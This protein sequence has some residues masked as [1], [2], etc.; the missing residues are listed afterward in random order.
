MKIFV[1]AKMPT[2]KQSVHLYRIYMESVHEC[3]YLNLYLPCM[4][5][6]QINTLD[7]E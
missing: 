5:P 7:S 1:I 3:C 4:N 2:E 6:K